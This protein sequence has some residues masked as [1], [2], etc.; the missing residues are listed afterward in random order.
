MPALYRLLIVAILSAFA[1][2]AFAEPRP[3]GRYDVVRLSHDHGGAK[4]LILDRE[5][6]QLWTWSEKTAAAYAGQI[7]PI[8]AD[9]PFVRVIRVP[10]KDG[11]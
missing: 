7:T 8:T 11:R 3:A 9:G 1:A 10:Q 4:V 2:P 5:T 6:G